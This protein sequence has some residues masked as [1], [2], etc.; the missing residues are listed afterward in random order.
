MLKRKNIR[1]EVLSYEASK[2]WR[3]VNDKKPQRS[4]LYPNY[5]TQ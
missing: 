1:T 2:P 5:N 4:R 3:D